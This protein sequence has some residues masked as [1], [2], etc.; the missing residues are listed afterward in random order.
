M[1]AGVTLVDS[2]RHGTDVGGAEADQIRSDRSGEAGGE[3]A[4]RTDEGWL[5]E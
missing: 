2:D 1:Y 4:G 3:S 5:G